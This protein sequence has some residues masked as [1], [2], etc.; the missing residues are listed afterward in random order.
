MK[1]EDFWIDMYSFY[2]IF[3]TN[4]NI[5][6]RK[7]IFLPENHIEHE[8]ICT[9]IKSKFR[10]V[11]QVLSIEEWETGLALKSFV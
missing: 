9:I 6:I 1:I 3:L 11:S 7:L 5:Q 10:N 2:V 4:E 8:E